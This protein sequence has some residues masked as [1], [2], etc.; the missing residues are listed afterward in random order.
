MCHERVLYVELNDVT[1]ELYIRTN[2]RLLSVYYI[3][4]PYKYMRII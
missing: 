3:F 4:V 2:L 1:Y